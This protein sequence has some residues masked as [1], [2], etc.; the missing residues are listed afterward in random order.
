MSAASATFVRRKS[1]FFGFGGG[2]IF[3][4]VATANPIRIKSLKPCAF[5]TL[6]NDNRTLPAGFK[7]LYFFGCTVHLQKNK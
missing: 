6:F 2:I 3:F 4:D 7:L 5:M 1:S